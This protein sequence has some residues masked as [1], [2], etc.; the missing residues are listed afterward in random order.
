MTSY[1]NWKLA[2]PPEPAPCA[3][4][5]HSAYDHNND[6]QG[7]ECVECDCEMYEERDVFLDAEDA[8]IARAEARWEEQGGYR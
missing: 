8:A 5:G 2:S 1:D 3:N 6:A 4:C 7:D